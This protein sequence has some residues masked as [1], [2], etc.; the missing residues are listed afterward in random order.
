[1]VQLVDTTYSIKTKRL[2][3]RPLNEHDYEIWK[4]AYTS[5]LPPKNIYDTAN[6]KKFNLKKSDFKKLLAQN[7]K[8]RKTEEFLDYAVIDKKTGKF[9]GRVSLMNVV[10]SVTQSAFLGYG[11]FNNYW[12]QGYAEEAVNGFIKLAFTKYKLHRVVAGIEPKNKLSIKLAKKLGMRR[13]GLSKNIILLR[14]QWLDLVQYALTCEDRKIKW[15][16]EVS[17]RKV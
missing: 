12:G 2:I 1:M 14:G 13:E 9:I 17:V 6:R 7:V 4:E 10:R 8:Y 11:L 5:M 16:G 15:K 3:I